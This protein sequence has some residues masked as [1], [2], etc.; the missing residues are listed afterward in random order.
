MSINA[1]QQFEVIYRD[2]SR[3][4]N[5][6]IASR[7]FRADAHLAEDLTAETFLRM[8]RTL[9][10]GVN[11]E[12]PRAL[13]T[14][15][16][17]RVIASHFQRR[18][19]WES[20]TDFA[21]TNATEVAS[22]AAGTPH[23]VGLLGELERAKEDLAVAAEEYKAV[24][25]RYVQACGTLGAA[26]R[27]ESVARSEERRAALAEERDAALGRFAEAGQV[28]A[29]ARAAWNAGAGDLHDGT[30]ITELKAATR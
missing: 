8:W 7:L 5:H 23:L 15:M 11:V 29:L 12:H 1:E 20:A 25:A 17:G 26:T 6:F 4:I 30:A 16:A 21:L 19:A 2:H 10:S 3:Q 28:V 18:S 14:T 24:S 9:E 22:G 27:P 13:L